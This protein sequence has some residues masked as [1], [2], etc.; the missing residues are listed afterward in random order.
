MSD[1][2]GKSHSWREWLP[3]VSATV[4]ALSSLLVAG[5]AAS[6]SHENTQKD[7]V[8]L[9][10]SVL[11]APNSSQASKRWAVQVLDKLSPVDLPEPMKEGLISGKDTFALTPLPCL[12]ELRDSKLL[13]TVP[14]AP[15]PKGNRIGDWLVFADANVG[16]LDKA[17]SQ[18]EGARK[19]LEICTKV[20]P[21]PKE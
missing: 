8:S 12:N 13:D 6:S 20:A 17:N 3:I 18:L 19:V 4:V 5:I 7:Y 16:Q 10:M 21:I 15:I 1:L 2:V 11:Q 9:A 14:G